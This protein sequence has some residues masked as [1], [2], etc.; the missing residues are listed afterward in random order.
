MGDALTRHPKP[1]LMSLAASASY[2]PG[3]LA[4]LEEADQIRC[5][6]IH[7]NTV[8][9]SVLRDPDSPMDHMTICASLETE[10]N[11][12]GIFFTSVGC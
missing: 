9:T 7:K 12:L 6:Y 2:A 5:T 3:N 8:Y 11:P 4:V 10:G 1:S